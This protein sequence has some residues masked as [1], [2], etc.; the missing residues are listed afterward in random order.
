[1]TERFTQL[2][3]WLETCTVL[4]DKVYDVPKP[5]SNDA[6]FRRYYRLEIQNVSMGEATSYIIMDAPP[7]HEDCKPFIQVSD[8]LA[9]LGLNVPQVLA[10]D[11]AQGFLLLTDL[12]QATYFSVLDESNAETLYRD[13]FDALIILQSNGN[14]FANQLPLYDSTLLQTEINLFPD[15]LL[16]QHLQIDANLK[17]TQA[18]AKSA[19]FLIKSALKQPQVA[20]HRD[21][22]SRNLMVTDVNKGQGKNPGILDYQDAVK[23]P[24]TYDAVSMI[25]DCYLVWPADQVKEWQREYFLKLVQAQLVT[26]NEWGA[27]VQSMD[28]MGVQRHLKAA[29]IFARL[30]HRDGKEGYLNDIPDTV[31]YIVNIASQYSELAELAKWIE[32]KV[33]PKLPG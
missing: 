33:M 16:N 8:A 17:N 25:R 27:F 9:K 30:Y 12:G 13:A 23:G 4:K 20:V 28:W 10:Q 6:S 3:H 5:A 22:H 19:D 32:Q 14:N 24:L 11:L 15:W 26:S 18:W 31:Q 2:L 7:T 29:G 1:M 21:Y